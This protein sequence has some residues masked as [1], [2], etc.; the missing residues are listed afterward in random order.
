M[1]RMLHH[2]DVNMTFTS[3]MS[4]IFIAVHSGVEY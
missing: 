3:P 2:D 1:S 4:I